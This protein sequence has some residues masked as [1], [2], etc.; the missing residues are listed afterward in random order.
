VNPVKIIEKAFVFR[1]YPNK[2]QIEQINK[3]VGCARF[4]YNYF[5]DQRIKAY[6][7][8]KISLGYS[9]C[10]ALL[11]ELKRNKDYLWLQEVDKFALQ[12]SLRDLN[13]AYANFFKSA[14]DFPKFKAKHKTK[15]KYRTNFTNGNIRVDM[16]VKHIRLPKLGWVRFR[17]SKKLTKIP[18]EIVNATISKASSGKYFVSVLCKAEVK[19]LPQN[20]NYTGYDMGLEDLLIG[21]NGDIAKNPRWFRQEARKLAKLQRQLSRMTKGSSNYKKQQHKIA[22]QHEHIANMRKDFLHKLST[23]IVRE[24][25][26]ICLEDLHVKDMIKNKRL[27]KSIAD[28]GWRLLRQMII[29][30]AAWYGRVVSVIDQFY[31]SSKQCNVCKEINPML[32]LNMREWKC[33]ICGTIHH[34]DKN[35]AQNILDEGLR[36]LAAA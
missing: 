19:E 3:T 29:Y 1:I 2:Q 35:A 34:R 8:D 25:Q 13:T 30:K 22:R 6:R 10:S 27:A 26:V 9:K 15:Q 20:S 11:T 14:Q 5:L 32:T 18:S 12:N 17:K 23:R 16:E 4:V 28:A 33:P 21:S 24:N 7:D 31:P 36:L